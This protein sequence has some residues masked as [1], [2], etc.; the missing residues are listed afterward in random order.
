MTY[1][2]DL[3]TPNVEDLTDD[4][5]DEAIRNLSHGDTYGGAID[6]ALRHEALRRGW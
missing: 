5:L 4:Q 2:L 3:P 1:S 6:G